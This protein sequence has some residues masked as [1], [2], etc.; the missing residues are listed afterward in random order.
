MRKIP[1][2]TGLAL[3]LATFNA[4]AI[5]PEHIWINELASGPGVIQA[6][7]SD[8]AE[9]LQRSLIT[10]W[11]QAQPSGERLAEWSP[12]DK[13]GI[14]LLQVPLGVDR[15]TRGALKLEQIDQASVFVNGKRIEG[16]GE[17]ELNLQTGDHQLLVLVEKASDWSQIGLDWQGEAEHDV[18]TT[19]RPDDY[20][21]YDEQIYDAQT[22]IELSLAPNGAH[23]IWRRQHF[24][25]AT[26]DTPQVKLQLMNTAEQSTVF[27]WTDTDAAGFAWHE[28]SD[29]LAYLSNGKIQVMDLEPMQVE[30]VTADLGALSNLRWLEDNRLLFSWNQSAESGDVVAKRYQALEDRWSTFRDNSQ[31]YTL[32]TETGVI[33]QLTQ[34]PV[35]TQL[36]D[37]HSSGDYVLISRRSVDYAEPPHYA[38][39]LFE[40]NVGSGEER[41]IGEYRTFN[42]ARYGS[43]GL[44]VVAG[45]GFAQ[46]AGRTVPD[47]MLSNNYDGQLYWMDRDGGNLSALSREFD[48]ALGGIYSTAGE[49]LIVQATERDGTQLFHY[50]ASSGDFSR[51]EN[52]LDV[53]ETATVSQQSTPMVAYAGTTATTP[54]RVYTQSPGSSATLWWNSADD[55]YR[56]NSFDDVREW[57]FNNERGDT[58][59]GRIYLPHDFDESASYPALVYYY[60]GT[61]PVQR[62][63]TGRY[64][65]NLWADMGYVVYVLQPTGAT[66]FGQEFSARHVN[67]WGEYTAN[68]IIE[69]TQRFIDEHDFVDADRVGN[70]GASYGG[71]MTMLLATQTDL[72]AASMSHA[73]ISNI[74]SYWGQGWWGFLYSGEA[75][76]GSF[77][78]NNAELYSDQSP[79]FHADK[80]SN[81]MLLIHGD[82]DTNVP[83]G[84]SHN[85]Y[86]A[87][88]LLDK[89][90][91]LVEYVGENHGINRRTPRL[92]WWQTYMAFFDMHLKDQP[93][94]WDHLYPED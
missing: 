34:A 79:V 53:I 32:D 88:K 59:Y 2:L 24:S 18:L 76:K 45:P 71:F 83:P 68:D 7:D 30:T 35:S 40:I 39:A 47:D 92:H 50:R 8:Q 49:D 42:Q 65:F 70:L 38:V 22:T 19:E 72:F 66:G 52:E 9:A 26:G 3:V 6:F 73:G 62:A 69:G 11:L 89:D 85:M 14:Q 57:N 60:G 5:E 91:E 84:E 37:V 36:E 44:Y 25:D 64:P 46:G 13:P 58:I 33:A 23:L 77:P 81:P 51:L 90:V 31:L 4:A 28:H 10:R 54:Q 56:L 20:R 48:P 87:L 16:S 93:Q 80:V 86:T 55:F 67:A 43:D 21:L 63:F 27:E 41:R 17:Y 15:F 29:K 12:G 78:W 82:A 61:S 75:S 94:W 74:T 1:T